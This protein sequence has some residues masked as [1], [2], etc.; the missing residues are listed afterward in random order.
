MSMPPSV[1]VFVA[2]L[3]GLLAMARFSRR[4]GD[5][6]HVAINTIGAALVLFTIAVNLRRGYPTASLAVSIAIG[7]L[8]LRLWIRQGRPRGLAIAEA[9]AE[10][11]GPTL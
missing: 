2:F 3:A 8:F 5:R 7:G 9:E 4:D 1:A 10:A 11:L 6:L